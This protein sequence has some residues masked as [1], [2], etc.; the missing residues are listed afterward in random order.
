ML[1]KEPTMKSTRVCPYCEGLTSQDL[2]FKEEAYKVRGETFEVSHS[3]YVCSTCGGEIF[4]PSGG[5]TVKSSHQNCT[6]PVTHFLFD[7][8]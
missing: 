5:C 3:F 8:Y 6:L 7:F 4:L 1:T 2:I